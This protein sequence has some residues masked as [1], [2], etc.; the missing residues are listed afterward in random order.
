[1]SKAVYA[2]MTN[3][4]KSDELNDRIEIDENTDQ[5]IWRFIQKLN[6]SPEQ[7]DAVAMIDGRREYT[8]RQMFRQWEKYAEVF[9]ALGITEKNHA[10]VGLIAGL[11]SE[12]IMAFYALNMTGASVSNLSI[13]SLFTE[14]NLWWDLITEEKITDVLLNAEAV[15]PEKLK[16]IM[17]K[18]DQYG[19]RNLIVLNTYAGGPFAIPGMAEKNSVNYRELHRIPGVLFMDDL[20]VKYEAMPIVRS[21][22]RSR[23][24]AVILHSSGTTKGISTPIPMSDRAVN[25]A[26][27]MLLRDERYSSLR[28]NAVSC[29]AIE[30][31]QTY[32][33]ID[34]M[35]LPL[36]YGGTV[37]VL[38]RGAMN[39]MFGQ[40]V[41]KYGINVLFVAAILIDIYMKFP[42]RP[43]LS[44][45]QFL[46]LGGTYVS[47][48]AKKRYNAFLKQCGAHIGVSVGYGLSELGGACFLAESDREDDAI[49]YPLSGVRVKIF[50]EDEEKYYDPEDGPR[51]GVLLLS[52]PSCSSGRL[53][54]KV[55][56]ELEEIDGEQYLNTYDLVTVNE[57]GSLTCIGRANKYFVNN[58]GVRFDAGLVETAVGAQPGIGLCGLVPDF[59]KMI[60][61]TIP[62]LYVQT[63]EAGTAPAITVRRALKDVFIRDNRIVETNLPG[64]CVI[65]DS[66]PVN[67]AGKVD[68]HRIQKE[69]TK[70]T[71]YA[72]EPVRR[73]GKLTDIR[74]VPASRRGF[75]LSTGIPE[76]L[77]GMEEQATNLFEANLAQALPHPV[78]GA[79][80][81]LP[82]TPPVS[83]PLQ[84]MWTPL[85]YHQQLMWMRAQQWQSFTAQMVQW[86]F[87]FPP[88]GCF[89][90]APPAPNDADRKNGE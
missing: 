35:H 5:K 24:E 38:P 13:N 56:F 73:D 74:L 63:T 32:S 23:E 68:V 59:N 69:H 47:A 66:I 75:D 30:L 10:R 29:V 12:P 89:L 18:K 33:L 11:A 79:P 22:R 4:T 26:A 52:A 80:S 20:L 50:D 21:S 86:M 37:V 17:E 16:Q 28:G 62:V 3:E 39:P 76:E 67:A 9:S 54:D 87:S 27:A 44:S 70:G 34:M 82:Q 36:A 55:Y 65:T 61:D 40:A 6:S 31:C 1:M 88:F 78:H 41:G 48:D 64:R 42:V 57:D 84:M 45:L 72:V 15:T 2:E 58:E 77:A 83:S 43:D 71:I 53:G 8:Y 7:L 85:L 14:P 49:G 81:M 60:H 19:L 90:Q 51:T 25:E 46:F